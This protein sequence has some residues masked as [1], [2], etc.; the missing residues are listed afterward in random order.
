[1]RCSIDARRTR[2][3]LDRDEALLELTRRYFTSHGPATVR[4]FS[5]WSGLTMKEARDGV[6]AAK[7]LLSSETVADR[8]YWFVPRTRGRSAR[9]SPV[10]L[11]PNYDECL[12]AYKDRGSAV[13]GAV[14]PRTD[15]YAHHVLIGDCV[16]GSWRRSSE[17]L[18]R[19]TSTFIER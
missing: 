15:L 6:G 8:T 1:M 9:I 11:L 13:E 5:W 18:A 16:V 19:S 14:G 12:I 3:R 17:R 7:A 2:R 10:Y 4:D